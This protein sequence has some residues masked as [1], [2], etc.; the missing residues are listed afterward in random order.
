MLKVKQEKQEK[1]V[2]RAEE[3]KENK[4]LNELKNGYEN[5]LHQVKKEKENL[6]L[7]LS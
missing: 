1:L 4:K 7:G 6:L 2:D 5:K 3:Q